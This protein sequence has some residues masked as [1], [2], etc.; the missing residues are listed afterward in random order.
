MFHSTS[1]NWLEATSKTDTVT[2]VGGTG[3]TVT[4]DPA[5][6]RFVLTATGEATPGAHASSHLPGGTDVIPDAVSGGH[7]GLMSGADAKFVRQDGETKTGAQAK[8]LV[9]ANEYTDGKVAEIVIDDAS[10]TQKGITQLSSAT[11]SDEEG[12]AATPKAVNTVR[13]LAL[14]QIGDLAELQTTDKDNLVDALNEVFTHVDEGKELVKTAVIVKGGTVA[15][16]SPHSFQQLA[17]GIET[18]ETSTVINGQQNVARTYA[19][20]IAANDPV[21]TTTDFT[22][23]PIA[24]VPSGDGQSVEYSGDGV[25]LAFAQTSSPY[26]IMYKR[27]GENYVR[28]LNPSAIPTQGLK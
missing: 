2:F 25:Y 18:I 16:T 14:S 12:E 23:I 21:Y 20:T 6:K 24:E 4:T 3:I 15:G 26:V 19:E 9:A 5:G 27:I 11:G 10:L 17:D 7:S 22:S 13:Q 1:L 8:A 28:L